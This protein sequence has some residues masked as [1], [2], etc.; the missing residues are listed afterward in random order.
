MPFFVE[1]HSKL[2][3]LIDE[4][5][6]LGEDASPFP[7]GMWNHPK[8]WFKP[9]SIKF[10]LII[11]VLERECQLL[12]LWHALHRE[13][14][15]GLITI[16][17]VWSTIVRHPEPVF[18]LLATF[19]HSGEIATAE[20]TVKCYTAVL[21]FLELL[22]DALRMNGSQVQLVW[23]GQREVSWVVNQLMAGRSAPS[24]FTSFEFRLLGWRQ[25]PLRSFT[26]LLGATWISVL[27]LR[28]MGSH[29]L[30]QR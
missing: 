29:R 13:V 26:R 17:L 22:S 28:L 15:P 1:F 2:V 9:L 23:M 30:R 24:S 14:N 16:F 11:Q 25:I 27:L 8:D 10:C 5:V 20:V 7:L 6:D 19:A 3:V 21:A 18:I 4:V 12:A